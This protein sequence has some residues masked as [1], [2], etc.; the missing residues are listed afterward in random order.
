V[1]TVSRTIRYTVLEASRPGSECRDIVFRYS[2]A[3]P[4]AVTLDFG[5]RRG[6]PDPVVWRCG[7]DLLA[8]GMGNLSGL[9]DVTCWVEG[10]YFHIALNSPDGH[11]VFQLYADEVA[12]FLGDTENLVPYGQERIDMDAELALLLGGTR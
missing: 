11:A 10:G 1:T 2:E 6:E 7:R 12:E 8:A 5:H 3:D 4:L 9:Q